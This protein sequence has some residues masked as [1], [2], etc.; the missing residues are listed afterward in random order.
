MAAI[1]RD[2]IAGTVEIILAGGIAGEVIVPWMVIVL[3]NW[4]SFDVPFWALGL[5]FA[6]PITIAFGTALGVWLARV[7][8]VGGG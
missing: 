1:A 5:I 3:S 7:R 6:G 4:L 2:D 8:R